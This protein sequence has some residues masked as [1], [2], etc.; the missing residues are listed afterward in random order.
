MAAPQ[1][2]PSVKKPSSYS[3]LNP[4]LAFQLSGPHTW[5]AA[6]T[7]VLLAYIY[8]GITYS[9]N[10]NFILALIL[11]AISILMQSAVNVLNDYFD[12]K[13]GTDSLENSSED[14]FDAVLVYNHL[15]PRTV[16]LY[17]ISLLVLAAILGFY[18]VFIT[19]WPLL[20]LGLIGALSSLLCWKYPYF[21]SACRR[22]CKRYCN[23]WS[24]YSSKL[25]CSIWNLRSPSSFNFSPL[26]YWYWNDSLY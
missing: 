21:L 8:S 7:P 13:K 11:L 5:A 16:L 9:G 19:G 25:L 14:A 4:S 23:G 26:Y 3:S 2:R 17:A 1:Q 10:I 24:Y 20:I 15:N 18:L 12:Y 6:L 22:V